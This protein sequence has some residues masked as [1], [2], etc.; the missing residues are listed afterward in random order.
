[1]GNSTFGGTSSNA[2]TDKNVHSGSV[3]FPVGRTAA[4]GK[5]PI[6]ITQLLAYA[7]GRG[8]GRTMTIQLGA[9]KT[10]SFGISSGSSGSSTGYQNC[11]NGYVSNGGSGTFTLS[12]SGSSYFLHGGGG[13]CTDGYG[14]T[15]SGALGGGFNY[16]EVPSAPRTPS[17]VA[18]AGGATVTWV[19]PSTNG[20][21]SVTGYNIQRAINSTFTAGV[22]TTSVGNVLSTTITGLS[23]GT[24]YWFRVYAKNSVTT[25]AST[26]S[27]ASTSVSV[28]V[29]DWAANGSH[30]YKAIITNVGTSPNFI[31]LN[32]YHAIHL[33]GLDTSQLYSAS[34]VMDYVPAGGVHSKPLLVSPEI[35]WL[36]GSGALISTVMGSS[37]SVATGAA[38]VTFP[39][40]MIP[41]GAATAQIN[42][43]FPSLNSSGLAN[44]TLNDVVY[45]DAAT[46]VNGGVVAYFDGG[47]GGTA[48]WDGTTNN[49]TSFVS[50]PP[51]VAFYDAYKDNNI[52]YNINVGEIQNQAIQ[53]T[54]YPSQLFAPTVTDASIPTLGTY[55]ITA[56][57]GRVPAAAWNA[58]GASVTA[59]IDHDT[60]GLLN[61]HFIG[62][63]TL[64]AGFSEPY[65]FGIATVDTSLSATLTILG[66][67]VVT[68]PTTVA[69]LTGANPATTPADATSTFDSPFIT[70]LG[71]LYDAGVWAAVDA[72]GPVVSIKFTVATKTLKGFGLT[73]GSIVSYQNANWRITEVTIG[74][75]QT[76]IVATGYTTMGDM[77]SAWSGLLMG[78][79][80]VAWQGYEFGDQLI[81]PLRIS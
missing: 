42:L 9:A 63:K 56:A 27:V 51:V 15:L 11:S 16:N 49:S 48:A 41:G 13:S 12:F 55:A 62:P 58:S 81:E 76:Q 33:A 26:T 35:D 79:K 80:D 71:T 40:L 67:G 72:A 70:D 3:G 44:F 29:G 64:I 10:G 2:F 61:L 45:A 30:S 34:I 60:P 17:V 47:S 21:A 8:G 54:N 38:T 37:F 77:D 59:T 50:I 25:A 69:L 78:D 1:M 14:T 46:F 75:S 6:V 43:K 57:E 32:L 52:I 66:A 7:R 18:T 28:F 20:G 31:A 65:Q 4:N 23:S 24:T 53:T 22:A 36:D 74:F 39:S 5:G 73:A 19:A 68:N